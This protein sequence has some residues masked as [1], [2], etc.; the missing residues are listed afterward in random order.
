MHSSEAV[1]YLFSQSRHTLLR[2]SPMWMAAA[3][4]TIHEMPK[5]LSLALSSLKS[6]I[7]HSQLL[8]GLLRP[9]QSEDTKNPSA[10]LET[11]ALSLHTNAFP[12]LSFCLQHRGLPITR[13]QNFGCI[14]D[15]SSCPLPTATIPHTLS[16]F[17]FFIPLS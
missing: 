4:A 2:I 8:K 16:L 5:S 14:F 17:F 9:G 3:Q 13:E 15:S 6:Q 12:S 7:P 10:R 11:H 1:S